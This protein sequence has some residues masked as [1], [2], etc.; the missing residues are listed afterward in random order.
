MAEFLGI[1]HEALP[2]MSWPDYIEW[3]KH[4]GNSDSGALPFLD[5][6]R[7]EIPGLKVLMLRR[8]PEEVKH[9]L[10][11][12]GLPSHLVDYLAPLLEA[13]ADMV[14]DY[15]DFRDPEVAEKIWEKFGKGPFDKERHRKLAQTRITADLGQAM[16]KAVK[17]YER[18]N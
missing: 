17:F 18:Y 9:S 8:D 4:N 6:I 13:D 15:P 11:E 7:A 10:T 14:V 12:I 1:S 3:Q 5:L 16:D 2:T